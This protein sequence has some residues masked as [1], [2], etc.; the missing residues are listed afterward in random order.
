MRGVR[1]RSQPACACE[2]EPNS[3][4][5]P[6]KGLLARLHLA[7]CR[8]SAVNC[9]CTHQRPGSASTTALIAALSLGTTVE[10][11]HANNEMT[12]KFGT[13]PYLPWSVPWKLPY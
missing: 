1:Q 13:L 4:W 9:Q 11:G 6:R 3:T 8:E 7:I 5:L 2:A 10:R 12:T